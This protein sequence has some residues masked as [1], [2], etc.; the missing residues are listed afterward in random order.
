MRKA[1][2]FAMI[3]TLALFVALPIVTA[4][5]DDCT[6]LAASYIGNSNTGKF[7]YSN[8]RWV[9]KMSPG[10]KVHFDSRQDAVNAGYV[11]CKVCR[12]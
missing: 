8:C 5:A 1:I 3:I 9:S 11:P 4:S 10:H 2:L 7:H 6:P 12:P